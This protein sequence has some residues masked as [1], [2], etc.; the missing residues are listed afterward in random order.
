MIYFVYDPDHP[1]SVI[2]ACSAFQDLFEKYK[3]TLSD[4]KKPAA[5]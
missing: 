3:R 2:D 5:K 1:N 4:G